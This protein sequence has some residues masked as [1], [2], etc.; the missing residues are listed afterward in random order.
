M[1]NDGDTAAPSHRGIQNLACPLPDDAGIA[2]VD[3]LLRKALLQI[4]SADQSN[5]QQK[6]PT[7]SC[8]GALAHL[9]PA[10][11]AKDIDENRVE[12]FANF[13]RDGI[14]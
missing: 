4:I 5:P 13:G 1:K 8:L 2:P 9:G 11:S 6:K 12:M 7:R 14:A 10:P 3:T